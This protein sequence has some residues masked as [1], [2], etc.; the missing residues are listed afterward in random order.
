[1]TGEYIIQSP[2]TSQSSL[3]HVYFCSNVP[4]KRVNVQ[5]A[6]CR[7]H[8]WHCDMDLIHSDFRCITFNERQSDDVASTAVYRHSSL[9]I[10]WQHMPRK[11]DSMIMLQKKCINIKWL[12]LTECLHQKTCKLW[13]HTHYHKTLFLSISFSLTVHTHEGLHVMMILRFWLNSPVI[14]SW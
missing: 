3:W 9:G 8:K 12:V 11:C 7:N 2:A 4:I 5:T 14:N 6:A 1:M 10:T 13:P